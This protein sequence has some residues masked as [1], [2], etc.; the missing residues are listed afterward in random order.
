MER[1]AQSQPDEKDREDLLYALQGRGAFRHFKRALDRLRLWED[2]N[3]F[4]N[5]ALEE[6]A[7]EFLE[8]E[9]IAYRRK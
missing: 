3:Q 2:W 1:F 4:R 5:A 6:I 9:G 7:I 8:S